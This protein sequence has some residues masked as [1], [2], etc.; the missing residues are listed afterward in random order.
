MTCHRSDFDTFSAHTTRT[1]TCANGSKIRAQ[2]IGS[3]K[4]L[5][6]TGSMIRLTEVLYAPQLCIRLFSTSRITTQHPSMVLTT[7]DSTTRFE[8]KD[9]TLILTSTRQPT[10]LYTLDLASPKVPDTVDPAEEFAFHI[11]TLW[12]RR[13]GHLNF[14]DIKR[15]SRD[16]LVLGLPKLHHQKD[17]KC[18]CETCALS[19]STYT[20]PPAFA[21][22]HAT[23]L[24]E[25][26]HMDLC[27]PIQVPSA[28]GFK[29]FIT[30]TDEYSRYSWVAFLQSKHAVFETFRNFQALVETQTQR[31]IRGIRSDNGTEFN[32]QEFIAYLK[33]AG[34]QIQRSAPDTQAQNGIAERLNRTLK[35]KARSMLIESD[36]ASC[37]WPEAIRTACYLRNISPSASIDGNLPHTKFFGTKPRV[38]HLRTFGSSCYVHLHN[39]NKSM[40]APKAYKAKLVGYDAH[41]KAYRVLRLDNPK[42]LVSAHV[43]FDE[44]SHSKALTPNPRT[45]PLPPSLDT[46]NELAEVVNAYRDRL[47]EG[48]LLNST[49]QSLQSIPVE[50]NDHNIVM[51]PIEDDLENSDSIPLTSTPS[52]S[53]KGKENET[54]EIIQRRSTRIRSAPS[55][56][57]LLTEDGPPHAAAALSGPDKA[58][59]LSA[60]HDELNS[61]K[62]NDTWT[63]VPRPPGKSIVGSRWVFKLKLTSDGR[64]DRYK[65]RLV[66]QGFTQV[67]GIDFKETFAPVAK[68]DTIRLVL[69]IAAARKMSIHQMDVKTA[70]LNGDIDE[71][72][73]MRQPPGFKNKVLPDHVCKL[74]RCIYGLKQAPRMWNLKLDEFL[75]KEGFVANEYDRCLY[76]KVDENKNLILILIYVDDILIACSAI[77]TILK[78]KIA[79]NNRFKMTDLGL[80][81]SFL[82]LR[83]DQQ[84]NG[85]I[86]I[87]Q[88]GYIDTLLNK[89]K[90]S[91]RS[92]VSVPLTRDDQLLILQ[93]GDKITHDPSLGIRNLIGSLLYLSMCTRPDIS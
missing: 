64:P 53:E 40:F 33:N 86:T 18:F 3:V 70:F 92:S 82:G 90:L 68:M 57:A 17:D 65:A 34:I 85:N 43:H 21:T 12:H 74:N 59:W 50:S 51:T 80:L 66:A 52:T 29:Y 88:P 71:D 9:G 89:F 78:I 24:L 58:H 91:E 39:T 6:A 22:N 48:L 32:N 81:S 73:Y 56:F 25:R 83:V 79:F 41:A 23:E 31:K 62:A 63:L 20:N 75:V 2:G 87:S 8:M 7:K 69:A 30:F 37:Y 11:M 13:Y 76:S 5:A 67:E 84:S 19:K 38:D 44:S 46:V 72:I 4:L 45:P 54:D 60:I 61:L 42:V 47:K 10:G 35:E 36:I 15:L 55:R 14:A 28:D 16:S 93:K 1:I 77:T 49:D 27:G 26:I